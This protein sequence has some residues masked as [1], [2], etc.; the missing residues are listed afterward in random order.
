M[1]R[2]ILIIL[3]TILLLVGGIAAACTSDS[4]DL[5]H[6]VEALEQQA[7]VAEEIAAL[8][9]QVQRAGMVATL[10]L[11]DDV[12]FHHLNQTVRDTGE[13]PAG[14][15]GLIRTALRAVA[16]TDWPDDLG[17]GA[18][19]FQEKLQA[20]FDALR[21]DDLSAVPGA[22]QTAHDAYHMFTGAAWDR[23]ADAAGLGPGGAQ[24]GHEGGMGDGM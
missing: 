8:H 22:S 16:V 7:S 24:E 12:G 19:D 17:P 20:F 23:L 3:G 4:G 5:E 13:A 1:N 2:R 15:N 18:Q 11:L 10:N 14:T 6:R 9:E 21:G